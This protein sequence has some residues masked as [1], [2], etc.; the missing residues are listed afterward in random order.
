MSGHNITQNSFLEKKNIQS[1]WFEQIWTIVN[2]CV[3]VC[4][5]YSYTSG[6]M[7]TPDLKKQF[8]KKMQILAK[9]KSTTSQIFI[10]FQFLTKLLGLQFGCR[11]GQVNSEIFVGHFLIYLYFS[12][13]KM[14][15]YTLEILSTIDFYFQLNIFL[16]MF[17]TLCFSRDHQHETESVN[18]PV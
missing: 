16:H 4:Y 2:Q 10:F 8:N 3:C 11:P 17:Y 13:I 7:F 6:V 9:N 12:F 15:N 14:F 5:W 18:V 1:I